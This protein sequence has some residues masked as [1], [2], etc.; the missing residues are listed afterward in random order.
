MKNAMTTVA[1]RGIAIWHTPPK[2]L[3]FVPW[4]P[5]ENIS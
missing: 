1:L 3:P 5:E 2:I 4:I